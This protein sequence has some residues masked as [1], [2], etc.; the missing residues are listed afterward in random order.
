MALPGCHWG[1]HVQI[2]LCGESQRLLQ[3]EI[4]YRAERAIIGLSDCCK[5]DL[6]CDGVLLLKKKGGNKPGVDGGE[7]NISLCQCDLRGD[8]L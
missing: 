6:R 2:A 7:V 8:L 4:R 5:P 1:T 3:S